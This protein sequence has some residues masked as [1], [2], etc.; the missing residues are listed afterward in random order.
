MVHDPLKVCRFLKA[1]NNIHS[2]AYNNEKDLHQ[3]DN[4]AVHKGWNRIFDDYFLCMKKNRRMQTKKCKTMVNQFFRACIIIRLSKF[5]S[6]SIMLYNIY[7]LICWLKSRCILSLEIF[8][9]FLIMQEIFWQL[10]GRWHL[11]LTIL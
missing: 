8:L 2:F 10:D 9:K 5:C 7:I 6:L 4:S 3:N 1:N 11:G